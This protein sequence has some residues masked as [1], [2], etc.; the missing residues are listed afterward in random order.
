MKLGRRSACER[1]GDRT[2]LGAHVVRV[3]LAGAAGAAAALLISCGSSGVKLIP[4]ANAGPLRN[5]FEAIAQEAE[6]ADGDCT[7]TEAAIAKT[8]RDF[9]ALPATVDAGLH[10]TLRQGIANLREHALALCARPPAQITTSASPKTARTTTSTTT[11]TPTVTTTSTPTATTTTTTT[12]PTT[13]S[14]GG[15]TPAP[16][17]GEAPPGA[18]NGQGGG[19]GVGEAGGSPA[20]PGAGQEGAK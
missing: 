6:S 3:T 12:P 11:T 19:T 16:G 5:D 13:T 9:A 14:A 8:E 10:S 20:G 7:A 2:A 4:T 17:G 18:G 1:T 15:G